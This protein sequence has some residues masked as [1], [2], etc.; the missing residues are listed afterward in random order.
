M[1]KR[2]ASPL[3]FPHLRNNSFDKTDTEIQNYQQIRHIR[4]IMHNRHGRG[5]F[6]CWLKNYPKVL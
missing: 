2:A 4:R 5:V 6:L 3:F 1:G